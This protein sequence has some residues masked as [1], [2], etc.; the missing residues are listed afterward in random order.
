MFICLKFEIVYALG[1]LTLIIT[2]PL[3]VVKTRLCLQYMNDNSIPS[4]M[5]Y[6]GMVDALRKVYKYEGVRGLYKVLVQ[7][8]YRII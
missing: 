8:L 2:N 3:W 6:T 1:A 4:S 7:N 5:R